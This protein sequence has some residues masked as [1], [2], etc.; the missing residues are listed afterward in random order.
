[1]MSVS[2]R[3]AE[4]AGSWRRSSTSASPRRRS[5]TLNMRDDPAEMSVGRARVSRQFSVPAKN[6]WHLMPRD[7]HAYALWPGRARRRQPMRGQAR[8]KVVTGHAGL[9]ARTLLGILPPLRAAR[10]TAAHRGRQD[11]PKQRAALQLL[12]RG[13]LKKPPQ[14]KRRHWQ[15][16]RRLT[17]GGVAEAAHTS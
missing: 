7:R 12:G 3:S 11:S 2:C 1:M 13:A 6:L 10:G 4:Q 14:Y 15:N 17:P 5:I 8:G 16:T 9:A